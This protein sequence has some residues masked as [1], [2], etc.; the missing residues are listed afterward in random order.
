MNH[1]RR[2]HAATHK[3]PKRRG[4]RYVVVKRDEQYIYV[5]VYSRASD[6]VAPP[7]VADYRDD[8]PGLLN[9]EDVRVVVVDEGRLYCRVC[10]VAMFIV[11][12]FFYR[13]YSSNSNSNIISDCSNSLLVVSTPDFQQ[14]ASVNA[15]TNI[16]RS[17][18][19]TIN[20]IYRAL[21]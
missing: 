16:D 5:R 11:Y 6:N 20:T 2:T 14:R 7:I 13:S 15:V 1:R 12:A 3:S 21:L 8:G 10:N 18:Y 9:I 19:Y 17:T 4:S